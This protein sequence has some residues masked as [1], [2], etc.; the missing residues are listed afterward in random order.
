MCDERK[1]GNTNK[2]QMELK[3]I[4]SNNGNLAKRN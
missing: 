3:N 4:D 1:N 2:F